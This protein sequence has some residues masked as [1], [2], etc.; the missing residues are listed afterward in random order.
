MPPPTT[1][2]DTMAIPDTMDMAADTTVDITDT[3]M[4][5][6][7]VML[8]TT[9]SVPLMLNPRLMLRPIP[10]TCM[11]ATTAML[12]IPMPMEL[13]PI[14][15]PPTTA[16]LLPHP[17]S[18]LPPPALLIAPTSSTNVRPKLSPRLMLM[19]LPT[20]MV[21][22][23]ATPDITDIAMADMLTVIS[24]SDPLMLPE[25]TPAVPPQPF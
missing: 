19:P 23:M 24:A 10:H 15:M 25:S 3:P 5:D 2:V 1:M 12:A 11:L 20:T 21:D 16:Q 9:A 13:M 17:Q 14:L 22:T 4:P 7:A 6:M 8:T 18:Q